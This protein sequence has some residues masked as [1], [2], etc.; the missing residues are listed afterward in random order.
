[1]AD[2]SRDSAYFLELQTKT[3]WG[4]VLERFADWCAPEP[5]IRALDVGTGPGLFAALLAQRGAWMIGVDHDRANFAI[6][7]HGELAAADAM[8]LPLRSAS[9]DMVTASNV[10]FLLPDPSAALR[11]MRRALKPGGVLCV[12]NPSEKMNVAAATQLADEAGL[13][14]LARD[15][16]INYGRRAEKYH[17]WSEADLRALFAPAGLALNDTKLTMGPGLVRFARARNGG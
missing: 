2:L 10:L 12:L 4:R 14:G 6:P 15:T 17:A 9:V 8:R 1:M 16:L 3:G 5:G 13:D 7:Q 11:E